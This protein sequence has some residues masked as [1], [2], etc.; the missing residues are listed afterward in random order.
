MAV[1]IQEKSCCL[2]ESGLT[3][4]AASV[5]LPTCALLPSLV[6]EVL[7]TTAGDDFDFVL[8]MADDYFKPSGYIEFV[9]FASQLGAIVWLYRTLSANLT[10]EIEGLQALRATGRHREASFWSYDPAFFEAWFGPAECDL[11]LD[12]SVGILEGSAG[13]ISCGVVIMSG[14]AALERLI[15]ILLELSPS[16]PLRRA[17]LKRKI[18]ELIRSWGDILD[19]QAIN[20]NVEWLAER[21]NTFA[22][23]LIDREDLSSTDEQFGADAVEEALTRIG[24]VA[25]LLEEGWHELAGGK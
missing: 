21:R 23:N 24:M 3:A 6:R 4:A 9:K 16:S 13:P 8:D 12:E 10:Q 11:V 5:S 20:G 7:L 18:A 1:V 25:S 14:T 19:G 17:G 2:S 22:H 15:T